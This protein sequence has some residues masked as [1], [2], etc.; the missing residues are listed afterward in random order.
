MKHVLSTR[1]EIEAPPEVVWRVLT[2]LESYSEWNPFL[3][4]SSGVPKVG[5]KLVNRMEPPGGRAM[6]FKPTVTVVEEHKVF[7]WLGNAG[8]PGLFDGRHRFELEKSEKGTL[9]HHSEMFSGI[10]VRL[11][12]AS[13][14]NH[15]RPGFEA[16][17]KALKERAER[18]AKA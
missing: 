7:E 18:H 5:E 13:L 16:M 9:L 17:N 2:H 14:N 12:K 8:I 11:F 10:L 6:T 3:V 15:T 4:S 1:I